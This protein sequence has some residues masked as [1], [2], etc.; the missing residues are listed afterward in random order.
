MKKLNIDNFGSDDL[1]K[2]FLVMDKDNDR[3]IKNKILYYS[4]Q[5]LIQQLLNKHCASN[6]T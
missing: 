3:I 6:S 5:D 1:R 2:I 4:Q